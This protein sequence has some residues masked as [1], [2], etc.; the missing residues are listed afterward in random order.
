MD[1][2]SDFES[3]DYGFES[4]HGFLSK[5]TFKRVKLFFIEFLFF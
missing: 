4:R 3:G 2:V 1:K 5:E